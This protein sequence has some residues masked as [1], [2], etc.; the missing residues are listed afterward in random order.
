MN[1]LASWEHALNR[2]ESDQL[3]TLQDGGPCG[4]DE[5]K[6]R[7]ELTNQINPRSYREG[8]RSPKESTPSVMNE[9]IHVSTVAVL[10]TEFDV[11]E[12]PSTRPCMR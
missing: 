12:N 3:V 10:T 8:R 7:N 5:S 6:F 9:S 11:G 4:A 2:S 1:A